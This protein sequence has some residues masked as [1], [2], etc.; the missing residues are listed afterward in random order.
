M[1]K[2]RNNV[3]STTNNQ[4]TKATQRVYEK[5]QKSKLKDMKD[6]DFNDSKFKKA[7]LKKF[8]EIQENFKS[9]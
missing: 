4:D 2:Q 1:P 5:F 7:V 8:N 3:S 9:Q 6:C